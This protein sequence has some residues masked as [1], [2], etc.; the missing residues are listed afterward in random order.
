MPITTTS[1]HVR[2]KPVDEKFWSGDYDT[3]GY[4]ILF[5]PVSDF[6]ISV[7]M[8]PKQEIRGIK[9]SSLKFLFKK[10]GNQIVV[11]PTINLKML[12]IEFRNNA[13]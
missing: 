5:Q 10:V 7:Q 3:G 9:V 6:P 13:H 11:R 12:I 4:R 2:W 8:S 1:V